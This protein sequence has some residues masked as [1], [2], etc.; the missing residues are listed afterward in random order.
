LHK[1]GKIEPLHLPGLADYHCHCDYSV[2]ATG[3][4]DDYCRAAIKKGLVEICFTTHYDSNPDSEGEPECILVR[5]EKKAVTPDNLAPYVDD[6]IRAADV[7][8]SHGLSVKLGLEFGWYSNCE[9]KAVRLKERFGF[10]YFLC[11]IHEL[12]NLCF[13][14]HKSFESCVDRYSAE[15]LVDK[16]ARDLVAATRSGLFDAIAHLDY[17]RKYGDAYY[18]PK[19]REL[20]RDRAASL[21]FAALKETDTVLEINTSGM[22]RE[23]KSYYP[24][25]D[26]I[27]AARRAGV[28]VRYLGSDA[29]AP[30]QVAFEF[31]VVA[32]L[33][34]MTTAGCEE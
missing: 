13:S 3:S 34:S 9:E 16:H 23:N 18:G 4:I 21:I 30:E 15:K 33:A 5:G 8:H 2:D 7:Y 29:H 10:Q 14:C 31:D 22:R 27:N 24:S 26:L 28:D 20:F 6:V 32:G 19:L 17:I 11:G 12:D 25:I 1:T